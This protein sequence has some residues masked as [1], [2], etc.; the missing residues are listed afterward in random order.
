MPEKRY[1]FRRRTAEEGWGIAPNSRAGWIATLIFF[2]IDTGGVACLG[3]RMGNHLND[4]VLAGWAF[5]WSVAFVALMFA[6]CEP[7]Q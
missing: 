4:E 3:W 6:T 2:I 7:D 5:G 1:W